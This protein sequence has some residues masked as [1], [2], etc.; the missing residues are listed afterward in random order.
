MSVDPK[1]LM[2]LERESRNTERVQRSM[3]RTF[4]IAGIF[5]LFASIALLIERVRSLQNPTRSL[6]CDFSPFVSCGPLF[7]R[8]QAS[9]FGFPNPIL[10]VAGFV[11]PI[12]VGA[13]ILAGA[14]F[15]RW[16]WGCL[17]FGLGLAWIFVTWLFTQSV[18]NI[19][20]LCPYCLVVWISTIPMWWS[21]VFTTIKSGIW[22]S[23]ALDLLDTRR[24]PLLPLVIILNYGL[25]ASLIMLEM[26]DRILNSVF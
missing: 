2:S 9:I 24:V 26:G 22:G 7:D 12:V 11:V 23:S 18:Y 25:I 20:V 8:W 3:A 4:I 13:G 1:D 10:G 19:G 17:T 21:V 6:S 16:F 14:K 15:K 5:G